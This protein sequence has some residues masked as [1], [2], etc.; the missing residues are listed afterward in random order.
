MKFLASFAAALVLSL[1]GMTASAQES[2][3]VSANGITI[4]QPWARATP[5][6]VKNGAAYLQISASGTADK[7]VDARSDAAERVE[8]HNHVQENGVMRMRRVESIEVPAG[9][10]V[11]LAPGGYHLMLM[12]LKQPL[13]AGEKLDLTLVFEKAGEINVTAPIEPIGAKGTGH[14]HGHDHGHGHGERQH[15]H[16]H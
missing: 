7:L 8:L 14:D 12:G 5:G 9:G 11:T 15:E 13:K 4:S 3:S 10:T 1:L 16:K 2:S 6:G